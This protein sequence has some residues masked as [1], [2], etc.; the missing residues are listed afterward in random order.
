MGKLRDA[1]LSI[2][3]MCFVFGIG[4]Q[5]GMHGIKAPD[6]RVIRYVRFLRCCANAALSCSPLVVFQ[7]AL[8]MECPTAAI[9]LIL[10]HK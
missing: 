5:V 8:S 10:H 9:T 4:V 6:S 7:R 2:L 1:I 3:F